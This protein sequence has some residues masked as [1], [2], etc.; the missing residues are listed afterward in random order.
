MNT[1]STRNKKWLE[2]ILILAVVLGVSVGFILL[3]SQVFN[4]LADS[5]HHQKVIFMDCG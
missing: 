5:F 2:R 3:H 4:R 1:N